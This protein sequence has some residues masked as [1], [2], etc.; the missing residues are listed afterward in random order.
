MSYNFRLNYHFNKSNLRF[1]VETL[2]HGDA[3]VHEHVHG[4][5]DDDDHEEGHREDRIH[6]ADLKGKL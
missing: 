2:G 6:D 4:E 1:V 3:L 5:E